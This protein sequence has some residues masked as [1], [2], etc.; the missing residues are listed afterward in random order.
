MSGL[1][2]SWEDWPG[3]RPRSP[4][5]LPP[6][7]KAP[8]LSPEPGPSWR[9]E[10]GDIFADLERLCNHRPGQLLAFLKKH[11][12]QLERALS[13]PGLRPARVYILLRVV[14]HVLEESTEAAVVQPALDLVLQPGFMLR[15]LLGFVAD[16]ESF[17]CREGQI[18]QEV[19]GDTVAA[20]HHLLTA[21]PD[22]AHTL[23]CYPVDLLCSTVQRLQ[24]RGFQFTWV[25]Q[26]R[27][28]DT[29]SLLDRAFWPSGESGSRALAA[30]ASREDFHLIPVFPTPEDI[31]LEP[32]RKLKPNLLSGRYKSDLDYLDT[33]FRLLREDLIKPLRDGISS[34]FALRSLFSDSQKP[35][36][37]LR[38][39]QDVQLVNVG[40]SLA[41]ATY[42]AKFPSKQGAAPSFSPKQLLSGSLVCLLSNDCDHMLFGTVARPGERELLHG[43][44]WLDIKQSHST[45]LRLMRSTTSFTM[46]ESPAFFESYR[47]VLEGL[48]E[49]DTAH[50]PFRRYLVKCSQEI[51]RPLY[52]EQEAVTFDLSALQHLE[53]EQEDVADSPKVGTMRI[54][55]ARARGIV[56]A[57]ET[58]PPRHTHTPVGVEGC[59]SCSTNGAW[60]VEPW[61][62]VDD[63]GPLVD[64]TAVSPF[65]SQLWTPEMFPHL[66]E[67]QILAIQTALSREFVLI[68]GPPGTGK[69][70]IG[71]KILKVL[72]ENQ[73]LWKDDRTPCLVVCYTNHALDQFLEGVLRF[74]PSGVVRI[75]GR[76]K[77]EA[78]M[79]HSLRNLRKQQFA[80]FLL[81]RDRQQRGQ[82][83]SA[84]R[85]QKES[86]AYCTEVLGLLC[87]GVLSEQELEAELA[88]DNLHMPQGAILSWLQIHP[89]EEKGP[90]LPPPGDRAVAA[91]TAGK[92][93][94]RAAAAP[95]MNMLNWERAGW[96]IPPAP[97]ESLLAAPSKIRVPRSPLP[98]LSL[99]LCHWGWWREDRSR[100]SLPLT[101]LLP[102]GPPAGF[103]SRPMACEPESFQGYR[104]ERFLDDQYDDDQDAKESPATPK[105]KFAYLVPEEGSTSQSWMLACLQEGDI[106][107]NE[108]VATIRSLQDLR[109]KDHW[110]LYRRWVAA[111]E[112]ELKA[113]LA[114]KL[115]LYEKDAARLEQL[116]L[117][118]DL[119]LLRQSWV[120]GM[121][122]T[123]AAKYRKLL[124]HLRPR[125]V[126]VEE[127]AEIL[128]AH[129]L[130]SLTSSCHH[131][132]LIGDHQ[133]LRPKPADY[134]LEKKLGLGV[135]LFERMVNN[136]LP[137][138]QLLYQHRMRPEISQLL[139]PF[140]YKELRDHPAVLEYESIKG[141]EKSV[142]F[143]QH[144]EAESHST[145][146][147]SYSNEH[148]ATFLASLTSYL[149]KQGYEQSQITLL[150]PY[151]GQMVWIRALLKQQRMAD[152]A[153]HA[154]DEF[155]GEENDIVLLSL[156]RSNS[157]GRVG[158]LKDKNRL[159]VALSRAKKGF[160]CIGNLETLSASCKLWKEIS[161]LLKSKSLLGEEL[162]LM[163]Q[164][165]PDTRTAVKG[166]TDFGKLPDG[167]CTLKCQARLECGHPCTRRCHP[168]DR[169]H[170]TSL[171]EFPCSR[172]LCKLN[173]QCPKKCRQACEPCQVELVEKAIPRCGHR[174]MVPCHMP[175]EAWVCEEPC[176]RLLPCSHPCTLRCGQDC[177]ARLCKEPVQVA[178]PCGH[179][180]QADCYQQKRPLKCYEKC[181]QRLAC[182]HLCRGSCYECVQGR[183]HTACRHKCHRVLLCSHVCQGAC[184]ENCPP[185]KRKCPARCPHSRCDKLCGEICFPCAQ[186]CAWRCRHHR[187]RQTCSEPCDRPRCNKPCP[188]TL[189]CKHPCVGLCGEPCPPKCWVC[190]REELAEI[191]FGSEDEPGARFV[192]LEDCGH[193]FEVAGL[194]RWVDGEA[195][196]A[197]AQHVQQ[198]VCPKC[199]TPIQDNPRYNDVLRATRQRIEEVK[200]KLQG[201]KEA[202]LWAG[203]TAL[204]GQLAAV[205]DTGRYL[206]HTSLARKIKAAA[207]LQGLKDLENTVS[208][209]LSLQRLK[210]QAKRCT[211]ER[212]GQLTGMA[213]AVEAWLCRRREGDAFTAQQLQ[214]GRDEVRRISYL[215]NLFEWLSSQGRLPL[216]P[217]ASAAVEKALGLLGQQKPLAEAQEELLRATLETIDRLL[218]ATGLLLR[219][220]KAERVS[221]TEALRFGRG[222]WYSCPQGHLYAIGECGQPMQESR[223]PEC[224]ATIGGQHHRLNADNEADDRI[225]NPVPGGSAGGAERRLSHIAE[226]A[227]PSAPLASSAPA[228]AISPSGQL[229]SPLTWSTKGSPT[230]AGLSPAGSPAPPASSPSSPS[231]RTCQDPSPD[232]EGAK[233][234]PHPTPGPSACW[235]QEESAPSLEGCGAA[236]RG[237]VS[238]LDPP[239]SGDPDRHPSSPACT[240]PMAPEVSDP[241]P[242]QS[243]PAP[244]RAAA[245]SQRRRSAHLAAQGRSR[246][247][248]LKKSP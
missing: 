16:L 199:S 147:E 233:E 33:H 204:L 174:Q 101:G 63:G 116:T 57:W 185:C 248:R 206:R 47:H 218:P 10:P 234:T 120:I 141:I 28:R 132:I 142:F 117:Q 134:T 111:Y 165:H 88:D 118:E 127:A 77:S 66:D 30:P 239:E 144:R 145:H 212:R 227:A 160:Y 78:V 128:E 224:G 182:G 21:S 65:S 31:F 196:T 157:Q 24:C 38:L 192:L 149:L 131:L 125:I 3:R 188:R 200:R 73:T 105:S 108:E 6:P 97:N 40:T 205:P 48:Q 74:Q 243:P 164:N 99:S 4:P 59:Q 201:G 247:L 104:D 172:V 236:A 241:C 216:S 71:L 95:P 109:L 1:K 98:S 231:S 229:G 183:M 17:R 214:E 171:C 5:P 208:F 135:S 246:A 198:L 11:T 83:L 58:P 119:M 176:P 197:P 86:I 9:Q 79:A 60:G 193:V 143:V 130:T 235:E 154:V 213:E 186:P 137:H 228:A 139:V 76:S 43:A 184:C 35:R 37:E 23:L 84:L 25:T 92:R 103:S 14:K 170:L 209:L 190:H 203:R 238:L 180:A 158:F 53:G 173:H 112:N 150:T 93:Q 244:P 62:Q 50:V 153:A 181:Q 45:L 12:G 121:T 175:A 245:R 94:V 42:L 240:P 81:G 225:L 191:F 114:E 166:S 151:H 136:Q 232:L 68:Q 32:T 102:C 70:F 46:V 146:S 61:L 52:L 124:Q 179:A 167:G 159:C 69:T 91:A 133:Q 237:E 110:R 123:G 87:R 115:P 41:G 100:Q 96:S 207:S 187:C 49:L 113:A 90:P 89:P 138:V 161:G 148:E 162:V 222:H 169:D 202:A 226:P 54:Q 210:S 75:R 72:L 177:R 19:M 223:C 27:L 215:A 67:S 2:R 122:T 178:L 85:H 34:Q 211:P 39:Y 242:P 194:D 18:S 129:V 195:G 26:K 44:V 140:F 126:M 64:L 7:Y 51:A 55:M 13:S 221:I 56:W 29:K 163:C 22:Q 155:Q 8:R 230:G 82:L 217:E 20:L 152:V 156:V 107:T 219:L 15:S 189:Q 168:C 220:S 36:G 106:M 80:G